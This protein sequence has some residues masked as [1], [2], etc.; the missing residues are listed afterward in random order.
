MRIATS[1]LALLL[2]A[3]PLFAHVGVMPR[4]SRPGAAETYTLRVPSEGGMMTSSVVLDVPAD[5]TVTAV[6]SGDGFKHE[7]KKV[8]G[9]ITQ[10]TWTIQIKAGA[11]AELSFIAT[12]PAQG[13]TIVWKVHQKYSDG[14][15][16]D[17]VGAVG[18]RS[19]APT[20][21]LIAPVK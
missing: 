19:P 6:P 4:E 16:S 14:M 11:S 21:K 12:N 10:I 15:S 2:T 3:V 13:D 7:E 18:S 9:R 20:T 8:G 1:V 17:W 5:V